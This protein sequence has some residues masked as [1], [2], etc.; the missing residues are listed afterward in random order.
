MG[1]AE[2]IHRFVESKQHFTVWIQNRIKNYGFEKNIDYIVFHKEAVNPGTKGLGGRPKKEYHVSIDMAKELLMVEGN[3]KGKLARRYFIA[4]EKQA[5]S[6]GFRSP[7]VLPSR[8]NPAYSSEQDF[9]VS[10][11]QLPFC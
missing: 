8:S 3:K 1:N 4:R 5:I 10:D 2:N 7:V 6:Q 11:S 9:G